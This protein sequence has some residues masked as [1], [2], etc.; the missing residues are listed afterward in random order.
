MRR[1]PPDTFEAGIET[2]YRSDG[3]RLWRSVYTYAASRA[4]AADAVAEA[5]AQLLRRR[6]A[7]THPRAWVWRSA[8]RI[9]AGMLQE[10]GRTVNELVIDVAVEIPEPAFDLLQA[11]DTLSDSQRSSILL[12]DYAGFPARE[13][14]QIIGSTEAAVRVHLMRARRRLR[15]VLADD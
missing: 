13:I 1:R 3:E 10:R 4:I 12:H 7:V 8:F 11:L 5:F 14:A 6:D 2:L 15:D 9:A